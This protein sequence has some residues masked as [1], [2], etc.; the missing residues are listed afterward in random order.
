MTKSYLG[1]FPLA[2]S[3]LF[4]NFV[5]VQKRSRGVQR[6]HHVVHEVNAAFAKVSRDQFTIPSDLDN[7]YQFLKM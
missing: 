2:H 1:N 6:V 7:I 4:M 3:E 5:G